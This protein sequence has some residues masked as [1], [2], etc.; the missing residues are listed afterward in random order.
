M[1][2]AF[3]EVMFASHWA[4][5]TVFGVAIAAWQPRL[6]PYGWTTAAN[7]VRLGNRG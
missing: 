7:A 5:A 3:L 2:S 6:T 4:L 1:T